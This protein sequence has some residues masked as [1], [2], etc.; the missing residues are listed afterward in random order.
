MGGGRAGLWPR[1]SERDLTSRSFNQ[2]TTSVLRGKFVREFSPRSGRQRVAHSASRGSRDSTLTPIPS[3]AQRESGAEGGVRAID[4]RAYA[5]GYPLP[6]LMGL[7]DLRLSVAVLAFLLVPSSIVAG[8]SLEPRVRI[9]AF[10]QVEGERIKLS[11]LLP[12]TAPAELGEMGARIILGDSPLPASRRVMTKDQIDQQL[13][14]FPSILEQL[15]LPDRLVISCRQRR[16]SPEEIWTAIETFLAA[17]GLHDPGWGSLR[18]LRLQAPVFVTKQ[19][20]GLEV[21]R[22]EPDRVRRQ[23]RFLLWT[24]SEPQVLPFYVSVELSRRAAWASSSQAE[25][26]SG[27][28]PADN[29]PEP[30][31][32]EADLMDF[33]A[34]LSSNRAAASVHKMR[35]ARQVTSPPIVLVAKGK[36]AKLVVET[37]TLR[38][39]TLVTPLESGVEGQLIRVKNLDTQRVFEAQVVG[40]GLLQARLAGE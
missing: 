37:E 2:L 14:D 32:T 10:V 31:K 15:E 4:P 5:L 20:P 6:P 25:I 26:G 8:R 16:L 29:H 30:W 11:D 13:R 33:S 9:P 38:M 1:P 28:I 19:D 7:T 35:S 27:P 12:P 23:I 22:M 36:P 39:T 21:K 17:E 18:A 40:A 3:P 34:L 24:S